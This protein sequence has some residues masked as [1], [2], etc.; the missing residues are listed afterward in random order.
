MQVADGT[1]SAT[2]AAGSGATRGSVGMTGGDRGKSTMY[3]LSDLLRPSVDLASPG[4]SI[5]ELTQQ[6]EPTASTDRHARHCFRAVRL[7]LDLQ[8]RFGFGGRRGRGRRLQRPPDRR[9]DRRLHP[10][11]HRRQ[12]P[13]S[14]PCLQHLVRHHGRGDRQVAVQQAA[15]WRPQWGGLVRAAGRDH[16]GPR[17]RPHHP[18]STPS[19][20]PSPRAPRRHP[21]VHRRP[22]CRRHCRCRHLQRRPDRRPGRHLPPHGRRL[23]FQ[24]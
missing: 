4:P 11:G 6:V 19:P 3:E 13:G 15:G 9:A 2:L 12:R 20:W 10:H 16:R 17:R 24:L 8:W 14:W 23:Q 7:Q 18:N 1:A 5:E 21:H 22:V